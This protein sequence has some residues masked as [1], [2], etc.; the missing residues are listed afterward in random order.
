MIKN[1][2]LLTSLVFAL[3]ACK[4]ESTTAANEPAWQLS[5]T[6]THGL[7]KVNLLCRHSPSVGP[8]QDCQ[9]EIQDGQGQAINE[10]K[11]SIDGG[12]PSHGHGLPTAPVAS[13]LDGQGHYRIDG[14]QYNM[15]GPWL[16][17]FII[18]TAAGQDKVI[19]SFEISNVEQAAC[20]QQPHLPA[21]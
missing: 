13:S 1:T 6:S 10:A 19:F 8:F 7:F 20:A 18:K 2:L 16:L 17:G 14:L 4:I 11:I 15:P 3:A 12:M 5:Q 9:V 21:T